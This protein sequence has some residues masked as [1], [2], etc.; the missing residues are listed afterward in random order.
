MKKFYLF[1]NVAG[2]GAYYDKVVLKNEVCSVLL[3]FCCFD[4]SLLESRL[5]INTFLHYVYLLNVERIANP[6]DVTRLI[7]SKPNVF[8]D[9]Q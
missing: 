6:L 9:L 4:I 8:N 3:V 7:D 5:H 1:Q 2:H